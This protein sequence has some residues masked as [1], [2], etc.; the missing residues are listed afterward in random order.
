M[1]LEGKIAVIAGGSLGIGK[2][3][4][5]VLAQEGSQVIIADI[6]DEE[7][8]KTVEE[9]T[10]LNGKACFIHT[11]T[12]SSKDVQRLIDT[13]MSRY[14]RIDVLYSSVA[15]YARGR[16][17]E[18]DETLWNRMMKVNINSAF[19]L[20]KYTLPVMRKVKSGS[21]ILTSSSVG[22]HDAAPNISAYATTKFAITGFTKAVACE[23][24]KD[25]IR[26]NCICPGP[27]DTPLIRA[28][29][30][31]DELN[32]FI[33]TIPAGRLADPMEIAR[34]VLFLASDDSTFVTGVALPVDGGQTAWV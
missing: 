24:L 15:I 4:A 20:T 13:V 27:T 1:R 29:R 25:N 30:T 21:I 17:E 28:S 19:L 16:V 6:N 3:V 2:A 10:D 26:V 5:C 23:C 31:P 34:S 33:S 18:F 9:I 32:A 7:G 14:A 8:K 12:S 11:D 22:Y